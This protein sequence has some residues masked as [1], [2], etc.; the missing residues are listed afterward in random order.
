MKNDKV[1]LEQILEFI[2]KIEL[3]ISNTSLSEFKKDNKTQDAVIRNI[4]I[5]GE[6]AN[7]VPAGFKKKYPEIK[8]K[9]IIGARN[10]LIHEYF[11]VNLDLVWQIIKKD[12]P[13]LNKQ[14]E[15]IVK[16]NKQKVL[17]LIIK[18]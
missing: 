11:G 1:I 12:L 7:K 9:S 14:I 6:A 10:I 18:K 4:E 3:Y 5:I 2:H 17:D 16:D 13:I 15:Q 8:W